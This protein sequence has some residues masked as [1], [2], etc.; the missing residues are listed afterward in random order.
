MA[1][2]RRR[3]NGSPEEESY[4]EATGR[5]GS[6]KV[7]YELAPYAARPPGELRAL[8]RILDLRQPPEGVN[9]SRPGLSLNVGG[10]GWG[11]AMYVRPSYRGRGAKRELS[12]V[13]TVPT[14][15]V[16]V[17]LAGYFLERLMVGLSSWWPGSKITLGLADFGTWFTQSV[18]NFGKTVVSGGESLL[19]SVGGTAASLGSAVGGLGGAFGAGMAVGP[20]GAPG[21]APATAI[22]PES[23]GGGGGWNWAAAYQH[24]WQVAHQLYQKLPIKEVPL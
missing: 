4:E 15:I 1:R 20:S 21:A 5:P 6:A 24:T 10:S 12:S 22:A 18:L 23:T 17:V 16:A 19:G 13:W 3:Y 2:R 7:G 9:V 8:R 14:G 11:S